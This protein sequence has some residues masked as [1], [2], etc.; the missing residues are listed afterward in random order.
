MV[1]LMARQTA[2]ALETHDRGGWAVVVARGELDA[3]TAPSLRVHL[4]QV[5]A[6]RNPRVIVDLSRVPFV[7]ASGLGVLAGAL[8]K[9]RSAGGQ[10]RLVGERRL[11]RLLEIACLHRALPLRPSVEAAVADHDGR[12]T[13]A[14]DWR[15][16]RSHRRVD[17]EK[18]PK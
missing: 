12:P 7:D 5:I 8:R 3:Y 9:A 15:D 14:T 1:A 17:N 6:G 10:L 18:E 11:A 4:H 16:P 13:P 2:F